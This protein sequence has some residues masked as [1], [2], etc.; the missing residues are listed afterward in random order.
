L[1]KENT[2]GNLDGLIAIVTGAGAGIGAACAREL[3]KR[4]ATVVVSDINRTAADQVAAEIAAAGGTAT[5]STTDVRDPDAL[6]ALVDQAVTTFGRLDIAVNNAGISAEQLPIAELTPELWRKTLDINLDGVFFSMRAEIPVMVAGGGGSIINMGSIL[7]SIA[8]PNAAAYITS[9]H[10]VLGMTRSAALDYAAAG[11]RVNAVG[12]GF[13]ST[14]LVR[15]ALSLEV[16]DELA[17][18]HPIGRM[19]SPEDVAKL[20]AF[21]ASDDAANITGGYQ[22]TDGGFSIR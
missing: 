1:N 5:A 22:I 11:V 10:A 21:L 14:E 13:V 12:P 3:A 19:A 2:M 17:V 20:V 8:W 4:G 16:Y 18:M 9:K 15:N 7:S 6:T